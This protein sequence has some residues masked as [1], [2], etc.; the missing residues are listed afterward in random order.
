[1]EG[2]TFLK[3]V[4]LENYR[5]IASCEV[6]L[7][8][9]TYLV[10]PNG[11]GKSNFLDALSFIA[12]ALNQS[13]AQALLKRGGGAQIC[14]APHLASGSF[15]ISL[16]FILSGGTAGQYVVR[17]GASDG[18]RGARWEVRAEDCKVTPQKGQGGSSFFARR[19]ER[20]SSSAD[21]S[22]RPLVLPDRLCLPAAASRPVFRSVFDALSRMRFYQIQPQAILD[23]ETFEQDQLLSADGGNLTSV[24][25]RLRMEQPD[26]KNRI[27]DYLRVV[28]PGLVK[29]RAELVGANG[30]QWPAQTQKV[31]LIFEQTLPGKGVHLFWASQMSDGT[32]RALGIL[33]ALLQGNVESG[34]R[35]TLVAIE[36]PEAQVNP[37]VLGVLRDAMEEA[38]GCS[39]VL[40]TT[41]SSDLLDNKAVRTESLLAVQAE[42]GATRIGPVDEGA[43]DLV[44]QRLYTLGELLRIG[45]LFPEDGHAAA[46]GSGS[47]HAPIEG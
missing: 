27:N 9:L 34:P 8:P 32:R 12:D 17:L 45:Q 30:Q 46:S 13:L 40:V 3:R 39:Q 10:G 26:V 19:G 44:R 43:R 14:H 21:L 24:L 16:E 29:V 41:H 31:A 38:S 20:V 6:S 11:S 42:G 28:L 35:P 7:G 47:S 23:I 22:E 1:M 4:V 15:Q 33:T 18:A 36:E 25:T 37:A 2:A 5:S